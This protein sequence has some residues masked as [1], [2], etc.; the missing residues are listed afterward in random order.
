MIPDAPAPLPVP[1]PATPS[2]WRRIWIGRNGIRAGWSLVVFFVLTGVLSSGAGWLLYHASLGMPESSNKAALVQ[3]IAQPRNLCLHEALLVL[4]VLV[5]T[6]VMSQIERRPFTEFGVALDPR[7]AKQFAHG[8]GIGFA[9]LSGVVFAIWLCGGLVFDAPVLGGLD[10]IECGAAWAVGFL[11]IAAFEELLF[12]GYFQFTLARGFGR[13]GFWIAAILA[14]VLFGAAHGNNPGES[15]LGL[16]LAAAVGLLFC[17]SLWCTRSLAWA[18]GWHTAWNW[19]ESCLF[20]TADSG[21]TVRGHIFTTHAQGSPWLSGGTT[22]PEGSVFAALSLVL[23][24]VLI[25]LT[26]GKERERTTEQALVNPVPASLDSMP[27][28]AAARSA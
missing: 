28:G 3:W 8:F 25:W 2:L 16:F 5:A 15:P 12:R 14:N 26:L 10:A 22:G 9:T 6:W 4:C 11:L 17:Y 24:G 19:A 20:G 21:T 7:R 13:H 18:I 1:P 27:D 23:T